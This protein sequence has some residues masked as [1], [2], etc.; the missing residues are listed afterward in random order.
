MQIS[1]PRAV[2]Q[3]F[4]AKKT[5]LLACL[6]RP[7]SVAIASIYPAV[8]LALPQNPTVSA[9]AVSI[10]TADRAMQI[11]Q[12]SGKA[13]IDWQK[14][15]VEFSESVTFNQPSRSSVVLNRVSGA[16]SSVLNGALN[17]TGQV[18]IINPNGV[19]INSSARVN[20]G[21]LLATTL[22]IDNRRFLNSDTPSSRDP[23][24]T[25]RVSPMPA[26]SRLSMAATSSC[27]PTMSATT[28]RWTPNR[29]MS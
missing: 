19:L 12:T 14:F 28:A 15:G 23:A 29:D 7:L 2:T 5:S 26:P 27:W 1:A 4:S 10:S 17:A 22:D 18:F 11:N 13:I 9:G 20:V 24:R 6:R 8:A 25:R 3:P 21:G 16:E